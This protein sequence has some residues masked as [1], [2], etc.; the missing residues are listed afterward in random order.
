MKKQNRKLE[1][2]AKSF[3]FH[4]KNESI[5]LHLRQVQ[6]KKK[7]KKP[8]IRNRK[9]ERLKKLASP[10]ENGKDYLTIIPR[11]RMGSKSRP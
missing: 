11:A 5:L 2:R 9:K 1:K 4:N 10:N 7:A 8:H 3:M 6:Y